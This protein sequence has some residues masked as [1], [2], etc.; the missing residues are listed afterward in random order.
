M[1]IKGTVKES[2]A[3][4]IKKHLENGAD[5]SLVSASPEDWLWPFTEE[6]GINLIA[7]RLEVKDGVY[8]GNI[9]GANCRKAEKV[10]RVR[11]VYDLEKY[12]DIYAYGDSA[13]DYEMLKISNHPHFR[14]F[15]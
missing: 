12:S 9:V 10:R 6:Y 11:E 3:G 13:G 1:N 14:Y 8:T 5:V 2:A 7:T 4:E 15:N